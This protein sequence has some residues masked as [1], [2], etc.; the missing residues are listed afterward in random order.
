MPLRIPLLW[1]DEPGMVVKLVIAFPVVVL[2]W[3]LFAAKGAST[4]A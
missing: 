1:L 4:D 3:S 2:T